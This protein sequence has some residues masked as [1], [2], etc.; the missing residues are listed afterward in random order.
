M[1][2]NGVNFNEFSLL[3]IDIW[4][5]FGLTKSNYNIIIFV[6]RIKLVKFESMATS[7]TQKC[8]K[9]MWTITKSRTTSNMW[10]DK[11]F[12][13]RQL[14]MDYI[15]LVFSIVTKKNITNP[16]KKIHK[17]IFSITLLRKFSQNVEWLVPRKNDFLSR[18]RCM[19]QKQINK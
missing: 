7:G 2:I 11:T 17:Q 14:F 19:K 15:V 8:M 13:Q 3:S 10:T 9:T 5:N 4:Q 16:L 18:T 1:Y 6:N 12:K